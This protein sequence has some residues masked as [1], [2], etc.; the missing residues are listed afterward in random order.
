MTIALDQYRAKCSISGTI[1]DSNGYYARLLSLTERYKA[2]LNIR[3]N[4]HPGYSNQTV[5]TKKPGLVTGLLGPF[6]TSFLFRR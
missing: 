6:R 5:E 3:L 1:N 2:F 4:V